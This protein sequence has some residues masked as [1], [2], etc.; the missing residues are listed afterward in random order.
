M[1]ILN[2]A[3]TSLLI[4]GLSTAQTTGTSK[5]TAHSQLAFAGGYLAQVADGASWKTII[6]LINADSVAAAYT[7]NFWNDDGGAMTLITSAGTGSVFTGTIPV[8]GSVTIESS[9]AGDN[10]N[11]GWGQVQTSQSVGGSAIFRQSIV[12]RPDFEASVPLDP[13]GDND[14]IL[15]FDHTTP[16]VTNGVALVNIFSFTSITVFIVFRNEDGSQ[17]LIDS[18]QMPPRTHQAFS[19]ADHYPG[20]LGHRGT[21]RFTTS[22]LMSILGLRFDTLAFSSI[23]P[24]API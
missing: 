9:G 2:L 8:N 17:I 18:I 4:S 3:L 1:K 14:V 19:L 13:A 20:T 7:L 15:P 12:G 16:G 11:R 21:V 10:L 24:L 23:T 6:V 5:S 22:G